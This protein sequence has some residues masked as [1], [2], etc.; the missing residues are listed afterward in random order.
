MQ[1]V[2]FDNQNIVSGDVILTDV[3]HEDAPARSL[4]TMRPMRGNASVIGSSS[5][6][7]K[8]IILR[9]VIASA[10]AVACENEADRL[11]ELLQREG[12]A[13][14]IEDYGSDPLDNNNPKKRTYY[15]TATSVRIEQGDL[16]PN[17]RTWEATMFVPDGI[18]YGPEESYEQ[19]VPWE[20]SFDIG[21]V[22]LHVKG[23]R[24]AKPLIELLMDDPE[25]KL[26]DASIKGMMVH[27]PSTG[28]RTVV[29]IP[30][31]WDLGDKVWLDAPRFRV[32]SDVEGIAREYGFIGELPLMAPGTN[33]IEVRVGQ[34]P[35]QMTPGEDPGASL[36]FL[37]LQTSNQ[38]V[39]Q[40]F[41]VQR[42]DA[43][44]RNLQLMVSRTASD[45][46]HVRIETD[47]AGKPS[48]TL[49]H[50][51]AEVTTASMDMTTIPAWRSLNFPGLFTLEANKRYWILLQLASAP[52]G[53]IDFYLN[54]QNG[55]YPLGFAMRSTDSGA[56]YPNRFLQ[57]LQFRING[58][59]INNSSAGTVKVRYRP[60]WR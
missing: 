11:K 53:R 4:V 19:V 43:T 1:N 5:L 12:K 7:A 32:E 36:T 47:V 42:T 15:C 10:T 59:G 6:D 54:P 55:A 52:S 34:V 49:V 41:E 24:P 13:L 22:G 58:G 16:A 17:S 50:A 18:G 57:S 48:G 23:N 2:Y 39:A 56:T 14:D 25:I 21:I 28:T 44:V 60:A 20:Y 27:V 37:F 33:N 26:W 8:N 45:N 51:N 46:L 40:C 31:S 29:T 3:R 30:A 38:R 35:I 9:G